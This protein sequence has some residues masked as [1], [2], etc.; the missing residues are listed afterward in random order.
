MNFLYWVKEILY[1][2]LFANSSYPVDLEDIMQSEISQNEKE[3]IIHFIH[4]WN[5]KS[6]TDE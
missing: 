4:M 6:Q 1:F 2:L 5:L 3:N